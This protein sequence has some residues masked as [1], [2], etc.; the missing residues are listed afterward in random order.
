MFERYTQKARRSVFFARY[1]AIQLGSSQI[2]SEHLLL[3]LLR[4]S[5]TL[6]ELLGQDTSSLDAFRKLVESR[7]TVRKTIPLWAELP[8]NEVARRILSHAEEEAENLAHR[9]VSTEHLLLGLL[10]EQDCSAAQLLKERGL[11]L[12]SARAHI[13]GEMRE[14]VASPPRSP[15]I[16]V[17]YSWER[18]LYNPASE[19]IIA[20]MSCVADRP[21]PPL[22]R[23][24]MRHKDADGYEQIGNPADDVSYGTPVTCEKQPIVIFNTVKWDKV[25]GGG[26]PDG[27]Y[28]FNLRTRELAVCVAKDSLAIPETH[29]RSWISALISLSDDGRT[30]FVNVGIEKAVPNGAIVHYYLASLD[31]EHKTLEL[32]SLLKDNRY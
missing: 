32:L 11:V 19:T 21:L 15:G 20:E 26:T 18:I 8:F 23:L 1:E 9:H 28:A 30:L 29:L 3:G 22:G 24:F 27:V 25:R 10:R 2:E 4:E 7:V 12:E 13:G 17:G 16:P 31:L 6:I 5:K 14:E